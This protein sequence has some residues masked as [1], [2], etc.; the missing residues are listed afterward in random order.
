MSLGQPALGTFMSSRAFSFWLNPTK[1]KETNLGTVAKPT[2]ISCFLG[3]KI[4]VTIGGREAD[5][6]ISRVIRLLES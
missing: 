6:V 3:S 4:P 2:K 5:A 1:V